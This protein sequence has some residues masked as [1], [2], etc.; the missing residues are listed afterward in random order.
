M[1]DVLVTKTYQVSENEEV[2]YAV[3]ADYVE[4][5]MR[6]MGYNTLSETGAIEMFEWCEA[7]NLLRPTYEWFGEREPIEPTAIYGLM[8]VEG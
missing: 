6:E 8:E 3:P 1:P 4:R 2:T 5:F 7:N